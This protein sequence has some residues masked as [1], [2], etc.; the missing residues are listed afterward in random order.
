MET[1]PEKKKKK[2]ILGGASMFHTH[3]IES[4]T[5]FKGFEPLTKG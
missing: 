3:G 4:V 1:M 5:E 2:R